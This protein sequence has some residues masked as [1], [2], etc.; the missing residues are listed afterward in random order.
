[1]LS[2]VIDR[3]RRVGPWR[4]GLLMGLVWMAIGVMA[5]SCQADEVVDLAADFPGFRATFV[6]RDVTAGRTVRHDPALAAARSAPCSTFK[7]PNSIIGLETDVVA[8]ESFVLPWDGKTRDVEA[9]NHDHDLRSAIRD[10]VV[11]YYQ[12]L[13]RRVGE[14][15]MRE[16]LASLR[17]GN[18]DVS[19]G[20]DRFWLGPSLRISPDEQVDFLARLHAGELP[21]SARSV[22][23]VKEILVQSGPPGVVYR[24]KTGSCRDPQAAAPHGWWVGSVERDARLYVFAARIEGEGASGRVCR[25]LAEKALVRL[26]VLPPTVEKK[27]AR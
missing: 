10:S 26:G 3:H 13:A 25:P 4:V 12:E 6:L 15:Q 1:M 18:Q 23:I 11:W 2:S 8:D 24:G 7:I 20:I 14:K 17:Y 5:V 9:W 27:E 22:G 19:G 16:W 21:T